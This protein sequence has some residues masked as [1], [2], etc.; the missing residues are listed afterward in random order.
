LIDVPLSAGPMFTPSD[1]LTA[2]STPAREGA[3]AHV[4]I[5]LPVRAGKTIV[6]NA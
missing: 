4:V 3:G 2:K 6:S 1:E 5:N